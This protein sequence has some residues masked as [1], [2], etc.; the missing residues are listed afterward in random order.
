[1]TREKELEL[2]VIQ[3]E[4]WPPEIPESERRTAQGWRSRC[5][6]SEKKNSE[7][8]TEIKTLREELMELKLSM[9]GF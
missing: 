4:D 5:L 9:D 2:R 1:M 7:Y 3:L 6:I 8:L